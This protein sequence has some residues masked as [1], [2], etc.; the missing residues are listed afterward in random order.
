MPTP[1][2]HKVIALI[3]G[4]KDSFLALLHCLAQ[5]NDIVALANLYPAPTS[6]IPAHDLSSISSNPNESHMY[7]TAGHTLIPLYALALRIPLYRGQISRWGALNR[8][9]DYS[10]SPS[11][12]ETSANEEDE[13]ESLLSLLRRLKKSH[14]DASAVCSGAILSTYQR[15]RIESVALRLGLVPLAPLWEYPFL[16]RPNSGGSGCLLEDIGLVGLKARIIKVSSG[17]LDEG[18]LWGDLSDQKIRHKVKT[19]VGRFGGS[20]LGEGG[21]YETIVV[22]GPRGVWSGGIVVDEKGLVVRRGE[23]GEAWLEFEEG[24]GQVVREDVAEEE[25]LEGWRKKLVIPGLW[26]D[27]FEGL[28]GQIWNGETAKGA[29]KAAAAAEATVPK[30]KPNSDATWI[31]QPYTTQTPT[32]LHLSNLTSPSHK[33]SAPTQMAN[34]ITSHLLPFLAHHSLH[35]SSIIFTTLLLRSMSDFT[36]LNQAYSSI[37]T[38]PLPPARVTVACGDSLPA[39]VHVMASFV[40]DLTSYKN[41]LNVQSRSY[42]APANIG[43]YSQAISVPLA[44]PPAVHD[45]V[46]SLAIPE[47]DWSST[48][49]LVYIAGQIPLVPITM[50]LVS[51]YTSSTL[52]SNATATT[53]TTTTTMLQDTNNDDLLSFR[54]QTALSL[55]HLFRIGKTMKISWWTGAVAFITASHQ[56][57]KARIAYQAWKIVHDPS[58]SFNIMPSIITNNKDSEDGGLDAWDKKYGAGRKMY[59]FG[60]RG[61]EE[62]DK[63]RKIPKWEHVKKGAMGGGLPP[64]FFAVEVSQLPRNALIEWSSLGLRN[65]HIILSP[66]SSPSSS[67]CSVPL[68]PQTATNSQS[69]SITTRSWHYIP[70]PISS[71]TRLE[72]DIDSEI[73]KRLHTHGDKEIDSSNYS[74]RKGS[75]QVEITVYTPSPADLRHVNGLVIPVKGVYGEEG[76]KLAAGVVLSLWTTESGSE[77]GCRL[78]Q[79][80]NS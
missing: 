53:I 28:V 45:D 80:A 34:I 22:D 48:R 72:L 61:Q 67:S 1:P 75:Q 56:Q 35:P 11:E 29:A 24:A 41:G 74:T 30:P 76:E 52:S 73:T 65:S 71:S 8:E 40:L 15:T 57:R 70:I 21:E 9:R 55:Q 25:Q 32:S 2:P 33:T 62:E 20:V 19:G 36:P 38:S 63:E 42:W 10:F 17:G 50:D 7:Q 4:G 44:P 26:D 58:S 37:F 23:A 31:P 47:L 64:G 79:A 12:K 5:M 66:S 77:A 60:G 78:S 69:K 51:P 6:P 54:T 43:P 68:R 27:G 59:C 14:P 3:S 18:L 13:T 16:P 39:G 46:S 49:G